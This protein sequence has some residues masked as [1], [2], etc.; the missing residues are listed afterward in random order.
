MQNSPADWSRNLPLVLLS[1]RV[2]LKE[3]LQCSPAELVY[4]Q[5]LR[6][7]QD[8]PIRNRNRLEPPSVCE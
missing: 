2:A 5:T 1:L 4:E 6:L 7:P 3:E 8:C